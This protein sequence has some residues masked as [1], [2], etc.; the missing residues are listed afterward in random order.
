M[1][2]VR[3]FITNLK[4]SLASTYSANVDVHIRCF[5]RRR[6]KKKKKWIKEKR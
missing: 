6:K 1:Q 3:L 5:Y 4:N 2:R